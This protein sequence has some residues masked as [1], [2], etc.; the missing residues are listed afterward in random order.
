MDFLQIKDKTFLI[1]GVANKKSIAYV[2]AKQLEE[3]GAKLIFSVQSEDHRT[4]L[5]KLFPGS[6]VYICDV[7]KRD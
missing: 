4:K 3:N 6:P 1:T 5:I 7:E 2:S